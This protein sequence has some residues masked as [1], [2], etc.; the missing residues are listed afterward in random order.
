MAPD[1]QLISA[2]TFDPINVDKTSHLSKV[3]PVGI[4][5]ADLEITCPF[6]SKKGVVSDQSLRFPIY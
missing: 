2:N 1:L 3:K 5:T 6:G 4:F